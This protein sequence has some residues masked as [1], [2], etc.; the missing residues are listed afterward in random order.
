MVGCWT[1]C[2]CV[3]VVSMQVHKV[4]TRVREAETPF[5]DM[6]VLALC[7]TA[8]SSLALDLEASGFGCLWMRVHVDPVQAVQGQLKRGASLV[9]NSL[10]VRAG[11]PYYA[12]YGS[13]ASGSRSA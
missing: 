1:I 8:T 9:M 3:C 5:R 4:L 7:V 10:L 6:A 2:V 12:S 11:I 13:D